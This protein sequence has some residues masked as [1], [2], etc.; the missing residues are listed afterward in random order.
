MPHASHVVCVDADTPTLRVAPHTAVTS[1]P[2]SAVM[3]APVSTHAGLLL[4]TRYCPPHLHRLVQHILAEQVLHHNINNHAHL[5]R[6]LCGSCCG[7]CGRRACAGLLLHCALR[8]LLQSLQDGCRAARLL[9]LLLAGSSSG[10]A[11]G[12]DGCGSLLGRGTDMQW[13][14]GELLGCDTALMDT[15]STAC[16]AHLATTRS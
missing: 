10:C 3:D 4:C 12:V 14:W 16:P 15:T 5:L 8:L 6:V 7:C 9:L 13:E 2:C 1:H 11:F